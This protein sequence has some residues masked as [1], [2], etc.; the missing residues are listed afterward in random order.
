[1]VTI[2]TTIHEHLQRTLNTLSFGMEGLV[3]QLFLQPLPYVL[4]FSRKSRDVV[5]FV[6][7]FLS[8]TARRRVSCTPLVKDEIPCFCTYLIQTKSV[9]WDSDRRT[10]MTRLA[11]E[12]A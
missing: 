1:M 5:C 3:N 12:R 11:V 9:C 8:Q 10:D 6:C 7:L 2:T 4:Y